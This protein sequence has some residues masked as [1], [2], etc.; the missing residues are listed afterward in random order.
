MIF[1]KNIAGDIYSPYGNE[2]YVYTLRSDGKY[3]GT[4]SYSDSASVPEVFL[5][6]WHNG[7][8]YQCYFMTG[9][10][11]GEH[12]IDITEG[13]RDT[14][15]QIQYSQTT[16][17]EY[18]DTIINANKVILCNNLLCAR[19]ANKLNDTQKKKLYDLQM[20]LE[21]RNQSLINDGIVR[22]EEVSSPEGYA[23]LKENLQSFMQNGVG[24]VLTTGAVIAVSA[25]VIA[26]LA[27]AAYFAY[28]A[29]AAEATADV[30]FSDELTRTLMSKLTEEEYAQLEKE[31]KGMVT[32]ASLK[33]R[34]DSGLSVAK[35]LILGIAIVAVGYII[36]Q[37]K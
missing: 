17:Q 36:K 30:K 12:W 9:D 1:N 37:N 16:A 31:T 26:S 18:I 3:A 28:R 32:K 25:V 2:A 10:D 15:E 34:L 33:A 20:R 24:V 19:F 27:T 22:V 13:W 21:Q 6:G 8:M 14:D 11:E 23:E 7:N 35:L 29:Y 5:T 4:A